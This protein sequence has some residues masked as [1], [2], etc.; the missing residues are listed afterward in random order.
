MEKDLASLHNE[1]FDIVIIGGGIN[2]VACAWDAVLRGYRVALFEKS[3]FGAETSSQSAKIAH[4]GIR[5]LQHADFVRMRESIRE[6]MN[7]THNA[8]HIVRS[9]PFLLPLYGHGLKGRHTMTLY[10]KIFDLF[11]M[12]GKKFADPARDVPATRIIGPGEVL[13]IV[14][15]IEKKNLTGGAVW[16]EGLMHNTERLLYSY[17]RSAEEAG[18]VMFNYCEVK[19]LMLDSN[20][21]RGVSVEDRIEGKGA[22]IRAAVVIN[23]SGPWLMRDLG[24]GGSLFNRT[25]VYPSK[26]FSLVTRQLCSTHAVSFY[27]EPMYKD[28][29]AVLD[30]KSSMQF[31]IPWQGYSLIASHQ[32]P[33]PEENPD[34]VRITEEEIT[35]YL[36]KINEGYPGANLEKKDIVNVLWG[37]I[38]AEEKG[39]A[40]P[41][42]HYRIIDHRVEDHISG[43]ISVGGVKYTTSRDVAEKTINLAEAQLA[44]RRTPCKTLYR[45]L[46]GGDIDFLDEFFKEAFKYRSDFDSDIIAHLIRNYGKHYDHVLRYA[47]KDSTLKECVDGTNILKAEIVHACREEKAKKLTDLVLRRTEIGNV[48]MPSHETMVSC[49]QI[50]AKELGWA[51]DRVAREIGELKEAYLWHPPEQ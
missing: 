40:A 28:K 3:D 48:K 37:I 5:Y 42:K 36:G 13:G 46:W 21:V 12:T 23:A 17:V 33:C 25:R 11:S 15:E 26:G 4:S 35:E 24:L 30:K 1:V 31:A 44:G 32:L 14:P 22:E 6:R 19:S 49:A 29:N 47:E 10:M 9:Q 18:A 41:L 38:P 27:I 2:G 43:I 8:P 34:Q 20:K 16:S 45:P 50:M 7:L 39:S 51:Q